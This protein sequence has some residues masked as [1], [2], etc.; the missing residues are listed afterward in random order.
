MPKI[1][2]ISNPRSQR[3]RRGLDGI[4]RAVADAPEV[5]HIATDGCPDVDGALREFAR[6]DVGLLLINGGDGTVQTVL[7]RLL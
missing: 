3:N 5:I 6:Q 1:G 4:H 2:L 7:T